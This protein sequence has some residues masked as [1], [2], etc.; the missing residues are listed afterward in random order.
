MSSH[1]RV[2]R[3]QFERFMLEPGYTGALAR[4]HPEE[5]VF[6]REGHVYDISEGGVCFEMDEPIEPGRTISLRID[7]PM[8]GTECGADR[9]VFVTG[10]VVWCDSDEIGPVRMALA[11]TRFDR[12]GDKGRMLRALTSQRYLRAA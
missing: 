2:N 9:S 4:V 7:L 1:A 3:R 8:K 12:A 6:V 5:E 10:N 11:I